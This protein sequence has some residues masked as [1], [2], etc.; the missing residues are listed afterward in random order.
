MKLDCVFRPGR[1]RPYCRFSG[2]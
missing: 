2:E 1:I